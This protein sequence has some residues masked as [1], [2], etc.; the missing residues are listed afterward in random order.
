MERSTI[1]ILTARS[2]S[3]KISFTFQKNSSG[4]QRLLC[5]RNSADLFPLQLSL[6]EA[7][8]LIT[9]KVQYLTIIV[10]RS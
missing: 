6:V 7:L 4:I 1:A 9:Q 8:A 5:F 10:A 3:M 2:T